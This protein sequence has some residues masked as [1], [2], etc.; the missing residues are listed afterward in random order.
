MAKLPVRTAKL[1]FE[2]D[3]EGI[4]VRV[5]LNVKL[6]AL[7]ELETGGNDPAL[8]SQIIRISD[9]L[10]KASNDDNTSTDLRRQ[11]QV[12]QQQQTTNVTEAFRQFGREALLQ[13]NLE[14]DED[15][16]IPAGADGMLEIDP[17]FAMLLMEQWVQAVSQ[18]SAPLSV[19]S[20]NGTIPDSISEMMADPEKLNLGDWS[21]PN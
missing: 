7:L 16:P 6:K 1:E 15:S 8:Q 3:Y 14:D 21:K 9:E 19:K 12:L 18:P 20:S 4:W 5:K 10:E 13:W 2:G 17:A 11:L